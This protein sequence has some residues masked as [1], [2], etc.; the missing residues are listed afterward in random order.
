MSTPGTEPFPEVPGFILEAEIGRGTSARVFRARQQAL[1]RPVALKV[2]TTLGDEG[3]K[4]ALRLFREA[5]LAGALDHPGI[6]RGIDAGDSGE[7]CW[8]AME[9]VEGRTLQSIL[10]DRGP[11]PWQKAI[12]IGLELLDALGH[13][14]RRGIIHRDLKPSNILIGTDGHARL[15]DL[16]LARRDAEPKLTHEGATVGT[17]KFMAP[18][19]ARQPTAVDAR[20]D[21]FSMGAVLYR[22]IGG[23]APFEGET[24]AAVLTRLFYDDPIPLT[25][26]RPETPPAVSLVVGKALEK[27]PEHRFPDATALSVALREAAR[28]TER[29]ASPARRI[30]AGLAIV[31]AAC[32]LIIVAWIRM[33]EQESPQPPPPSPRPESRVTVPLVAEF[34]LPR[35]P[36][37]SPLDRALRAAA[38]AEQAT[39]SAAL[40]HDFEA[41][42]APLRADLRSAAAAFVSNIRRV[43]LTSGV[44]TARDHLRQMRDRMVS[45]LQLD[46]GVTLPVSIARILD[47]VVKECQSR[48][49]ADLEK[50]QADVASDIETELQELTSR[51]EAHGW[52][53]REQDARVKAV[54]GSRALLID[55]RRLDAVLARRDAVL[56]RLAEIPAEA[57]ERGLQR[58]KGLID[59]GKFRAARTL[60]ESFT[61][62]E[63]DALAPGASVQA[64]QMLAG[65]DA[66]EARW[67][68][69]LDALPAL[70]LRGNDAR[71]DAA[72][73]RQ[74]LERLRVQTTALSSGADE[75]SG[76]AE[77]LGI[78]RE[79]LATAEAAARVRD[80]LLERLGAAPPPAVGL[81]IRL[82]SGVTLDGRIV[83]GREGSKVALRTAAERSRELRDVEDI[84][85]V[86]LSAIL[87][88]YGHEPAPMPLALLEHW[89]RLDDHALARLQKLPPSATR[90]WLLDAVEASM[91]AHLAS[92]ETEEERNAYRLLLQAN[93]RA[94]EGAHAKVRE[95]GQ[96]ILS[97]PKLTGSAFMLRH[98]AELEKLVQHAAKEEARSARLR[99]FGKAAEIRDRKRGVVR[100]SWTFGVGQPADGL[101][102]P[103]G[104]MLTAAGLVWPGKRA[105]PASLPEVAP[106][107]QLS[108]PPGVANYPFTLTAD[109]VRDREQPLQFTAIS[110]GDLAFLCI[111]QL[112]DVGAFGGVRLHG[113]ERDLLQTHD[114][115]LALFAAASVA[116]VRQRIRPPTG[117]PINALVRGETARLTL[118]TVGDPFA[119]VDE[120]RFPLFGDRRPV[121]GATSVEIRLPPGAALRS[122]TIELPLIPSDDE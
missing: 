98:R 47:A 41:A 84:A 105:D 109:V 13:A 118:S 102:R 71:L 54:L 103:A 119:A 66:A 27:K 28:M 9:L 82:C 94:G 14:H 6:V 108:L 115:D 87:A 74:R 35:H 26:L 4:R 110:Y 57:A 10:D 25:A 99:P 75:V 33:H 69:A 3:K 36:E 31:A 64:A 51:P 2:I 17:P 44:A 117:R 22:A 61:S 18:E 77:R 107:L 34:I 45:D 43:A 49:E 76:G 16:G 50:E 104:S 46:D 122:L 8:F 7:L 91:Q 58:A 59:Q 40:D 88:L 101:L 20:A 72:A 32:A 30:A 15:L 38:A 92:F 67:T 80:D 90:D 39:P 56:K 65:V 19:Q 111:G 78:V 42:V 53:L 83:V 29:P 60:L 24:V 93:R 12:S 63:S 52:T 116:E 23:V 68:A 1:D 120:Q 55:G 86:G 62:A 70:L 97:N 106:A 79:L 89:D 48:F 95:I 114:V 37:L 11:L 5:R 73:R 81:P 100:L 85:P 113:L 112:R 121:N 96:S 21:I